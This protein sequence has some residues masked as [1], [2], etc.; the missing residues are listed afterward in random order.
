[1]DKHIT[2]HVLSPC[3]EGA[4]KYTHVLGKKKTVSEL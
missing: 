2:I 3:A 4:K 1:M